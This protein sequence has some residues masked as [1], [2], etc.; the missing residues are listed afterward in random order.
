MAWEVNPQAI[1]MNVEYVLL[2]RFDRQDTKA[3]QI[4][5]LMYI[6]VFAGTCSFL[7]L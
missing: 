7:T 2:S 6:F 4:L 5:G 3:H 1:C